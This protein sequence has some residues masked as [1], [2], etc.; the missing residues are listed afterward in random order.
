MWEPGYGTS[1]TGAARP[2]QAASVHS[3]KLSTDASKLAVLGDPR[4]GF[5]VRF[6]VTKEAEHEEVIGLYATERGLARSRA[7]G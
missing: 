1:V 4:E 5:L 2:L 3:L 6:D 7:V